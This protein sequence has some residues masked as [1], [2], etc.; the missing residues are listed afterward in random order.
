MS[1]QE[2]IEIL[3]IFTTDEFQRNTS[4]EFDDAI[5]MAIKALKKRYSFEYV[6]N[7]L[8][9]ETG[10]AFVTLA[11]TGDDKYDFTY[12]EVL[13]YLN[14]AIEFIKQEMKYEFTN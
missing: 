5:D 8:E 6:L 7:K 3:E 10:I 9:E 1:T 2:A 4:S 12:N 13:A 11:N 14:K